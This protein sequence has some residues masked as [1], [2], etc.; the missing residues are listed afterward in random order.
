[1]N[2]NRRM[3]GVGSPRVYTVATTNKNMLPRINAIDSRQYKAKLSKI[4]SKTD[5]GLNLTNQESRLG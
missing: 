2:M 3:P 1:M 5:T 4:G